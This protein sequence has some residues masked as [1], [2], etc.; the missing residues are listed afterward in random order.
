MVESKPKRLRDLEVEHEFEL[1]GQNDRQIGRLVA[2]ENPP[3]ID[4]TLAKG[5]RNVVAVTH[6]AAIHG[7][8]AKRVDR[9]QRMAR[10]QCDDLFALVGQQ[11]AGADDECTGSLAHEGR[12]CRI[13]VTCC[14]GK[15]HDELQPEG[16][17]SLLHRG[18]LCH[19]I[20]N[21]LVHK[22]RDNGRIGNDFVSSA[23][24]FGARSTPKKLAPVTF[25]PG[26][27]RLGTMPAL[28]GSPP[29]M[30]TMGMVVVAALA[31]SAAA[32]V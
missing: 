20:R 13:D 4:A 23:S 30:K 6:Q 8:L 3:G 26:R 9:G 28:T 7:K 16:P 17:R 21:V 2:L 22:E 27:L 32:S 19:G 24:C 25:P 31:A 5:I 18:H 29:L 1:G 10:R 12:K 15:Q 11:S 14:A